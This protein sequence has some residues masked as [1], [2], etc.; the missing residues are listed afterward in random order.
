MR[1]LRQR[2]GDGSTPSRLLE[3]CVDAAMEYA[4]ESF[5]KGEHSRKEEA[6]LQ[7]RKKSVLSERRVAMR[8][9]LRKVLASQEAQ[10]KELRRRSRLTVTG[11]ENVRI[12]DHV[13]SEVK[14]RVKKLRSYSKREPVVKTVDKVLFTAGVMWVAL[15][16]YV[17]LEKPEL[18]GRWALTTACPLF[19]H[20]LATYKKA[21]LI[22]FCLDFC[23]F[24]NG[25]CVFCAFFY[26]STLFKVVFCLCNGPLV[27]ANVVWRISFLF[28]SLDHVCSAMLHAL[29][30]LWTYTV[31]W[32]QNTTP[33][34]ENDE[35]NEDFNVLETYALSLGAYLFWQLAYVLKTEWIDRDYIR[36]SPQEFTSLRWMIKDS[37][38]AMYRLC[39]SFLVRWNVMGHDEEFDE[40]SRR[41]K[42]TFWGAQLVYTVVTLAPVAVMWQ[43]R[44]VHA[45][46]LLAM[47]LIA[48]YNGASYYIEVFSRR[49]NLKF[50]DDQH[51]EHSNKGKDQTKTQQRDFRSIE[52][53]DEPTTS[54]ERDS[55]LLLLSDDEDDLLFAED[56]DHS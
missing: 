18:M 35:E 52:E 5:L 28:H 46:C 20:R 34:E 22:Y 44:R 50:Q 15:T 48:I 3:A 45:A 42:L 36:N 43:H 25:L 56:H 49:Y 24:V 54:T 19:V 41:T 39:K 40:S 32:Q 47:Y 26:D 23:Y 55:E 31:R 7:A 4:K 11:D 30:P 13:S 38:G 16:E 6:D 9:A 2:D 21:G 10:M 1:R 27:I 29:P 14:T 51:L 53:E 17:L 37:R 12:R 8:E 33:E